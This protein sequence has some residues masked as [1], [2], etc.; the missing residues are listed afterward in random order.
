VNRKEKLSV[1][2]AGNTSEDKLVKV[3]VKKQEKQLES[4]VELEEV[5]LQVALLKEALKIHC[6]E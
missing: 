4:G 5:V 6:R 3:E 1:A 2:V